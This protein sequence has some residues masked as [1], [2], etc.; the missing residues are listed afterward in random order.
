MHTLTETLNGIAQSVH[1][2]FMAK[3]GK[4]ILK[5]DPFWN[6]SLL[7]LHVNDLT[8]IWTHSFV[9]ITIYWKQTNKQ[10]MII[11]NVNYLVKLLSGSFFQ[12]VDLF[13]LFLF[14]IGYSI[15]IQC[16]RRNCW[17]QNVV[18]RTKTKF[19]NVQLV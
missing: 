18:K 15:I 5:S 2:F 13:L 19:P 14:L 17:N 6:W 10:M 7:Y 3:S 12:T 11:W 16:G 9:G 4:S 1:I 8:R